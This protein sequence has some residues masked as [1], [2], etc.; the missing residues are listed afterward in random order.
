MSGPLPT[1]GLLATPNAVEAAVIQDIT[2]DPI[3]VLE[4]GSSIFA[5][6]LP[7]GDLTDRFDDDE[8]QT[9]ARISCN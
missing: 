2:I 9:V 8:A 1:P 3:L 4:S 5:L 6:S 7:I